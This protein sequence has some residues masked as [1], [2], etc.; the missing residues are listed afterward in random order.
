MNTCDVVQRGSAHKD[1]QELPQHMQEQDDHAVC[2]VAAV[3]RRQMYC[4]NVLR[5][6]VLF[7]YL[8]RAQRLSSQCCQ[9][10]W[11]HTYTGAH[12][13]V[14]FSVL[15]AHS[16]DCDASDPS[17]AEEDID[18]EVEADASAEPANQVLF[19]PWP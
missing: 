8:A 11:E 15:Q 4:S 3:V 10:I 18:A 6:L 1:E 5:L 12:L 16:G 14:R 2:I 19:H 13:Y 9:G 7:S 17:D